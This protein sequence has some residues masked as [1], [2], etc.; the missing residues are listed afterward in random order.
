[1]EET[2]MPHK[3]TRQQVPLAWFSQQ[4]YTRDSM[5]PS[6]YAPCS[7][8]GRAPEQR[9]YTNHPNEKVFKDGLTE[10]AIHES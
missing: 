7:V 2:G 10:L 9:Q 5:C 8:P 6:S 4:T 1:M 3:I